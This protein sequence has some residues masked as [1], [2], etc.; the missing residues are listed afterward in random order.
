[1]QVGDTVVTHDG[2]IKRKLIALD[3]NYAWV[4]SQALGYQSFLQSALS[5]YRQPVVVGAIVRSPIGSN[6]G[7]VKAV[8]GKQSWVQW[9]G[10]SVMHTEDNAQLV[11]V[12]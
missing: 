7:V 11:V 2:G 1:M 12:E 10:T 3:G 4:W 9:N 6:H 5:P 8:E